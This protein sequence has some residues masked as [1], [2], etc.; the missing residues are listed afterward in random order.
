MELNTAANI[1][2]KISIKNVKIYLKH[3]KPYLAYVKEQHAAASLQENL[4]ITNPKLFLSTLEAYANTPATGDKRKLKHSSV[5]RRLFT[6]RPVKR[7]KE[8]SLKGL[9]AQA[10]Q[11]LVEHVGVRLAKLNPKFAYNI[12]IQIFYRKYKGYRVIL[13]QGMV[14]ISPN[15]YIRALGALLAIYIS[16]DKGFN[17]AALK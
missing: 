4:A 2:L 16:L 10:R 17:A 1:D 5:E 3:V 12:K 14:I 13:W 7:K 11:A 9:K 8:E 15:L 6:K